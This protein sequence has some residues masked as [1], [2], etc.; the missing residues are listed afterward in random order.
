MS[1]VGI[2]ELT[3]L[4]EETEQPDVAVAMRDI[5]ATVAE[6][7]P[8]GDAVGEQMEDVT[9]PFHDQDRELAFTLGLMFGTL[10]EQEYPEDEEE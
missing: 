5:E 2:S 9:L 10:M 4:A 3:D 6:E 8:N 1:D 7:W